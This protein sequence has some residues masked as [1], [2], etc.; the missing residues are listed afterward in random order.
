M[1]VWGFWFSYSCFMVVDLSMCDMLYFSFPVF[2]CFLFLIA[3]LVSSASNLSSFPCVFN[4]LSFPSLLCQ[5]ICFV[6]SVSVL[7]LLFLDSRPCSQSFW[8]VLIL[9]SFI[10]LWSFF[11]FCSSLFLSVFLLTLWTSLLKLTFCFQP[12]AF[13]W[14]VFGFTSFS[15]YT[16]VLFHSQ[17]GV[18]SK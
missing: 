9:F 2:V 16:S 13:V 6:P 8:F 3:I 10:S 17:P 14:L 7:L 11:G 18:K 1:M 12:S 5:S 15:C 4:S